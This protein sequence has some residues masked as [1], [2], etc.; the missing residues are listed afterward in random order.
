[1]PRSAGDADPEKIRTANTIAV[2]L[3]ETFMRMLFVVVV[4][5][6]SVAE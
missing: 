5:E 6:I 3:L 2:R 4:L 1:L